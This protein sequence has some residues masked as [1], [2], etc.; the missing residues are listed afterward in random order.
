MAGGGEGG[1]GDGRDG[2]KGGGSG[3]GGK[4]KSSSSPSS[5]R[6]DDIRKD[7]WIR[8]NIVVRI[9]SKKLSGGRYYK[10]KGVIIRVID[11]YMAEVEILDTAPD[12]KDGGDLI[13]IDQDDLET[14]VPKEGKECRILNGRGRGKRAEVVSL[15][16][17]KYRGTLKILDSG[18][19]LEKIHYEDFSKI[20]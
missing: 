2:P 9:I 12:A 17:A 1:G 7:Y 18:E 19:V 10:R 14:V 6:I 5:E 20:A 16:K 3:G 8:R 15:D 13:R 4:S 11:R